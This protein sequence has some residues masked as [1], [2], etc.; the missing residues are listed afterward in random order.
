M[1]FYTKLP[2]NKKE[3]ILFMAIVSIISVNIIGP[4]IS[5]YQTGFSLESY[6][7]VLPV[8]P[9]IWICVVALVLITKKPAEYMKS[10][11]VKQEDSFNA[12]II[13]NILCT[14]LMMSV[15]LTIVG[16]WI[17]SGKITMHPIENFIYNWPRNFAVA[18]A[19]ELFIAQPIARCVMTKLHKSI[20]SKVQLE[21]A[22]A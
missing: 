6:L 5:F 1:E 11:I 19:V 22:K 7:K 21:N 9:F 12:H 15:V 8:L 4:I 2:R 14:V 20:D 17:G 13:V 3:F 18:L 16:E 10:K